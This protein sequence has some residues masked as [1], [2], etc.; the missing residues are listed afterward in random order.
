MTRRRSPTTSIPVNGPA[1]R[2]L[3]KRRGIEVAD[4]APQI[5]ISRS[6]L[7]RIE[8]GDGENARKVSLTVFHQLLKVLRV[9]N[10]DELIADVPQYED[11]LA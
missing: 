3:R 8:L 11:A 2:R 5:G 7:T 1:L 6:Y 9:H 4:L 10:E